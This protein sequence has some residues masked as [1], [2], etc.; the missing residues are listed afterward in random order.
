M[1]PVPIEP[2][3]GLGRKVSIGADASSQLCWTCGTCDSE[4]P[5]FRSTQR[6]RPQK[7]VRMANLGMITDL[8]ALPDIWYCLSC[9]RCLQ[10]C[11]NTVKPYKLHVHLRE[12]ALARGV[13]S[14]EFIAPYRRL[15]VEFQRVRWR[16]VA[17]CFKGPLESMPSELWY[18]WLKTPLHD[19]AYCII[20][21]EGGPHVSARQPLWQGDGNACFTCSECSN[22]CPVFGERNVFDPQ[23]IIRMANLGLTEQL[24]KSPSLWLCLEC[25]RCSDYCSQRVRGY[26]LIRSFQ[27]QAVARGLVDPFFSNRLQEADRLIYPRFLDEIDLLLGLYANPVRL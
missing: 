13:V 17:H 23:R 18:R 11:P 4:C 10:G 16:T 8:M 27:V 2:H 5:V 3:L 22:C 7:T 6:L 19:S 9:R 21:A 20:A 12:Q 1:H 24:L 25:Q 26:D 14:R 15:F